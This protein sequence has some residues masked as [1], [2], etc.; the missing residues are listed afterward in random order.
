MFRSLRISHVEFRLPG[1]EK[2]GPSRNGRM[3]GIVR[4]FRF[5]GI[6]GQPREV[7]PKFRNETRN[8][9][10]F[11][12]NGKRPLSHFFTKPISSRGREFSEDFWERD[13]K[14]KAV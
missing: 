12:S 3:N 5:S 14:R 6:L 13:R 9:R 8:F 7:N 2:L 4:F 1:S 11:W 10:N